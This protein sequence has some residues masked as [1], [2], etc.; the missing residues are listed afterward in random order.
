[1]KNK[2]NTPSKKNKIIDPNK[3]RYICGC[4]KEYKSYPALYTHI[5]TKHDG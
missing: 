1:M 2:F 3:K 5:R 4:S